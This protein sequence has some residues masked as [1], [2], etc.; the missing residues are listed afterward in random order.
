[1]TPL[2]D[3]T[4]RAAMNAVEIAFDLAEDPRFKTWYDADAWHGRE[5]LYTYLLDVAYALDLYVDAS[6][7]EWGEDIYWFEV[8]EA[9][10]NVIL[11]NPPHYDIVDHFDTLI[12][13]T[14]SPPSLTDAIKNTLFPPG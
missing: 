10:A 9:I 7:L 1:M 14:G 8:C 6:G 3:Y 2:H 11:S 12:N 13:P 5:G 4:W